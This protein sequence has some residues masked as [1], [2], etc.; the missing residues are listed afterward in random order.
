MRRPEPTMGQ[1]TS[2][3]DREIA[4]LLH[5]A[6]E[7]ENIARGRLATKLTGRALELTTC[8]GKSRFPSATAANVTRRRGAPFFAY[9]CPA[10][11][12]FH[13]GGGVKRTKLMRLN[14]RQRMRPI[15]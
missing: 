4:R 14:R 11:G 12:F 8:I 3:I 2:E 9:K 5:R 13:L 1:P 15:E 7:A 10:C 6:I